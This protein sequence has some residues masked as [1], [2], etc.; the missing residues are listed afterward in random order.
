[1][2]FDAWGGE[3]TPLSTI[4]FGAKELKMADVKA[5]ALVD[6]SSRRAVRL[7]HELIQGSHDCVA[8]KARK[9]SL[10]RKDGILYW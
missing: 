4:N 1:M 6:N 3:P 10:R 2:S 5:G 7:E 8:G 9:A